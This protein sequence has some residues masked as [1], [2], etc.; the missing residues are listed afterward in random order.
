MLAMGGP[1]EARACHADALSL[2]QRTGDQDQQAFARHGLARVCLALGQSHLGRDH[3][4]ETLA[5]YTTLGAG[6]AGNIRAE[7]EARLGL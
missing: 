4:R 7:L 3:L 6:E 1:R 2:S 5:I